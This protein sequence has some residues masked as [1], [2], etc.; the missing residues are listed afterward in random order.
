VICQ[1]FSNAVPGV[2]TYIRE[3]KRGYDCNRRERILHT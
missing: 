2:V 1:R 3:E